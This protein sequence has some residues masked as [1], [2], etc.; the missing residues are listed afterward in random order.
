MLDLKRIRQEPETV[1]ELLRKKHVEVDF[2]PLL[3]WDQKR[4]ELLAEVEQLK[5]E[6]NRVSEEVARRKKSQQDA[7]SLIE[8][9]R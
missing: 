2:T 4:R 6:R 3:D 7:T 1:R 9:M 8:E 5:A